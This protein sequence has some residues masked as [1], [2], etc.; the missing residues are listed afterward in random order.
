VFRL[1]FSAI[2]VFATRSY[3]RHYML[4]CGSGSFFRILNFYP[5]WICDNAS[6]KQKEGGKIIVL[7]VAIKV[8]K[9]KIDFVSKAIEK[10]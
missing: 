9:F 3:T 2:G 4:C 7:L 1:P 6:N 5:S 8:T 10:I